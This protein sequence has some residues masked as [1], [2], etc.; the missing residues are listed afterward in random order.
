MVLFLRRAVNFFGDAPVLMFLHRAGQ[1]TDR[2]SKGAPRSPPAPLPPA[3]SR[4]RTVHCKPLPAVPGRFQLRLTFC[5]SAPGNVRPHPGREAS[6]RR[7]SSSA[8]CSCNADSA[9]LRQLLLGT[10]L[11]SAAAFFF[12]AFSVSAACFLRSASFCCRRSASWRFLTSAA[13]AF[14]LGLT[15]CLFLEARG[16]GRLG[17][18]LGRFVHH[19]RLH[20]GGSLGRVENRK[21]MPSR[22]NSVICQQRVN[23]RSGAARIGRDVRRHTLPL[24]PFGLRYWDDRAVAL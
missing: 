19:P 18:G 13:R 2:R 1:T 20:H 11:F 14:R 12:S 17:G 21:L 6:A 3:T 7:F 4:T 15:P 24:F 10:F 22:N 9:S 23:E 16:V 8:T 5:G